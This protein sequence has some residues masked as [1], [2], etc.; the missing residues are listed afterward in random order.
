MAPIY[1]YEFVVP[2]EV[3]DE[4][5]H[6]NNVAYVQWMQ[7]VAI[8]HSNHVGGTQATQQVGA[9]WVARSHQIE[10]L[11]PGFA[12]DRLRILTWI[13]DFRKA[14]SRRKYK[15][16]RLEDDTVLATGETDWVFIDIK[17]GRPRSV[18]E[19]VLSCYEIL[20]ESEP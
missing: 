19:A 20:T 6:I 9:T 14:R 17:T 2:S 11:R 16:L 4:N 5:N 8:A 12:G 18:P 15:F 1:Q 7:D 3:I 13:A 10:Y